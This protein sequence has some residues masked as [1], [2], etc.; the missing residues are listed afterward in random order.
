M[1]TNR[2]RIRWA[3]AIG[4]ALLILSVSSIPSREFP[5]GM[6]L[7][8]D[9]LLHALEYAIL[10]FLVCRAVEKNSWGALTLIVVACTAYGVADELHQ[11]LIPGR[12][13]SP[14]DVLADCVGSALAVVLWQRQNNREEQ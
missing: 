13:P 1:K 4:Y 11:H 10:A 7:N 6:P 14:W 12:F 9:K 5:I 2:T 3:I 8:V